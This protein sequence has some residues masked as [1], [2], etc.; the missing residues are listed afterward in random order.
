MRRRPDARAISSAAMPEPSEPPQHRRR[1]PRETAEAPVGIGGMAPYP[2][3]G[4]ITALW[5]LGHG[6][7]I[8]VDADLARRLTMVMVGDQ[9]T[10]KG[11]RVLA[12]D[13]PT[14][15]LIEPLTVYAGL[16][17][18]DEVDAV[19]TAMVWLRPKRPIILHGARSEA[20]RELART[21]HDHSIRRGFPFTP[22]PVVPTSDDAIAALCTDGGCG[23]LF[24]DLTTTS[25]ELPEALLRHLFPPH[26]QDHYHLGTIAVA[27]AIEDVRRCFGDAMGLYTRCTIG[28]RRTPWHSA[29]R[30]VTFTP[31]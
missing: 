16:G 27:S 13:E 2:A 25:V 31:H 14:R 5:V 11:Q 20:V 6:F 15:Q 19:L 28:F 3:R 7:E 10:Y 29:M 23:T 18:H 30:N 9:L 12:I 26:H 4:P 22:V 24:F 17:A 21:I 8:P 1:Q